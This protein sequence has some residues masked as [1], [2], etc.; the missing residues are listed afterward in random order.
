VRVDANAGRIVRATIPRGRI[1]VLL[2]EG[3]VGEEVHLH[4]YDVRRRITPS[5][6][7]R[8]IFRATI[9]G[10]FEVELEGRHEQVADLTVR[11]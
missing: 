4:G 9:P 11:P 6:R 10:R 5:G 2:V 1:V 3:P 8:L 7:V